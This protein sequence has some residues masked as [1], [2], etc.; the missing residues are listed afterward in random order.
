MR[1]FNGT[2]YQMDLP[3]AGNDRLTIPP[4]SPSGNIMCGSDFLSLLIT[5]YDTSEVA[6]IVSGPFEI[7]ACAKVPA[8]VNYVV[9]SLDEAIQRF[10]IPVEKVEEPVVEEAK[11]VEEVLDAAPEPEVVETV[12]VPEAEKAPAELPEVED[13]PAKK[14]KSKK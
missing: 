7:S 4:K 2:N 11:P 13:K 1:I 9:Q 12:D 8:A 14:K 10:S 3:Y 5:S 6:I